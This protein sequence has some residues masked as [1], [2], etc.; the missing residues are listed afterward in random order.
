LVT[1]EIETIGV[2]RMVRKLN[3][4]SEEIKDF[5]VPFG[6]IIQDFE[7]LEKK[8]F[9]KEGYPATF[10]PLSAKYARW[11]NKHFPGRKIMQLTG[12]L[13]TSLTTASG[14][15]DVIRVINKDYASRKTEVPYA[16]RHQMGTLG[17]TRREFAQ[18]SESVK[19]RWTKI[20][21]RWAMGLFEKYGIS[22]YS[23]YKSSSALR[24]L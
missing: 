8:I 15:A 19:R 3:R 16:H 7:E 18:A 23:D 4:V 20:I 14:G 11:K 1:I 10:A 21:H 12:R 24:G 2:E 6:F 9:D 22:S 5:T 17:M 13:Y